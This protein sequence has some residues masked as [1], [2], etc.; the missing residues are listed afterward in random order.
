MKGNY[1]FDPSGQLAP[2]QQAVIDDIFEVIKSGESSFAFHG[3]AGTGKTYT[4]GH[5]ALKMVER[6]GSH[7]ILF[8]SPTHAAARILRTKLPPRTAK[9]LTIAQFVSAKPC[10]IFNETKFALPLA[11]Q[12]AKIAHNLH[13]YFLGGEDGC[14]LDLKLVVSDESSMI[15]QANADCIQSICKHLGAVYGLVG[16]PYQLPPVM[17]DEEREAYYETMGV[18]KQNDD[19]I[20][21][22]DM[23]DQFRTSLVGPFTLMEVRRN[24]G[25]ILRFA[26]N[27]R[28][29]FREDHKLPSRPEG[30][31]GGVSGIYI[32]R[33]YQAFI[34]SLAEAILESKDGIDVA[35][36][37]YTNATVQKLTN[38]VRR[39]LYPDTWDKQF[40]VSEAV[41][42]PKQTPLAPWF[43][44]D[45][46]V[47]VEQF[48][49]SNAFYSTTY[50]VVKRVEIV[51]LDL[52][53]GSFDYETKG[54]KIKKSLAFTMRGVFQKLTLKSVHYGKTGIVYCPVFKDKEAGKCYKKS[55]A[56]VKYLMDHGIIPSKGES[57]YSDHVTGK[58]LQCMEAFLPSISS[59]NT[60]TIHKAQGCTLAR[61][62]IHHDLE[63][64]TEEWKNNLLYTA[65]TR[66]SA[67]EIIFNPLSSR[68]ESVLPL[69]ESGRR[70]LGLPPSERKP[71]KLSEQEIDD[72]L[73]L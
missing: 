12:H 41:L 72:L 60:M 21:S 61:A 18:Q 43:T 50:C 29:N 24:S 54:R 45:G 62:Y 26:T 14:K 1:G 66:A 48:S 34:R 13:T 59:A 8:I 44:E 3:A 20:Y 25:A 11:D 65:L 27:V 38:D 42:L 56:K 36:I 19:I 49:T 64:C 17:D 9:V 31:S 22:K 37:A 70:L 6:F 2:E 15:T 71:P 35:A 47:C 5:L 52:D 16:D 67:Q 39:L 46:Q 4:C 53:F 33:S 40:C 63:R 51:S 23:C 73:D 30:D 32:A 57:G 28:E 68:E 58:I 55:K 10:R 69:L 7:S